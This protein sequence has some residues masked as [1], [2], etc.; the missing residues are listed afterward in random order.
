[1]KQE[2]NKIN[3]F[4]LIIKHKWIEKNFDKIILHPDTRKKVVKLLNN[5]GDK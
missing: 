2:D 1:M 3:Y 5:F 4:W